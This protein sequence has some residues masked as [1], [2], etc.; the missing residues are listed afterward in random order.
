MLGDKVLKKSWIP[1][2]VRDDG[3]SQ[4]VPF[5]RHQNWMKETPT[6]Q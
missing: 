6:V 3:Q 4:F 5:T 2:Q 1:D